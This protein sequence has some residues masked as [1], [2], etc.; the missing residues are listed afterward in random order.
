MSKDIKVPARL[1]RAGTLEIR[2][3]GGDD[4]RRV[5]LSF[6]SEEA[7]LRFFGW[8]VLG[9]GEGEVDLSRLASGRAPLLVDHS[10]T[11]D[12]QV[13]VVERAWI[14]DGKG[15]AVVR[16][17]K[18]PRADEILA[19]V[20]DGEVTGVSVGYQISR[21]VKVGERDGEPI[22]RAHWA[23]YEITLCPIPA[24]PGVGVGRSAEGETEITIT[25]E[26]KEGCDMSNKNTPAAANTL[27]DG[28]R[29]TTTAAPV[30]PTAPAAPKSDPAAD[31]RA[32]RA[33]VKDIRT[34]GRK[35]KMDDDAVDAAIE[36]GDTVDKFQRA[37]L[38]SMESD[39]STATRTKDS[40]I[41]MSE[42]DVRSFSLMRAIRY[43]A[44]PTNTR[45][46]EA[47]AF[48]IEVSEAAQE[49]LG[50]DAKGILIPADVLSHQ[51]FGR[52]NGT[53][54]QEVG[55]PA[56][57]GALVETEYLDGSFIGLLRKRAALTRLG[58][59][60][61]SGLHGNVAIPRQTGGGTAYWVGEGNGP[62]DSQAA[63]NTLNMTPHTLAAAVPITRRAMLQTT[64][65]MEA[66]VRDDLIRTM[67]LEIDRVG[68]NG[69]ADPDAPDGL[70]DAVG[71]NTVAFAALGAP[72]W[73]EIVQ[74]ESEIG[75][76]DAD[77]DGM[78]YLF[79]AT[80]RG[81]L[82]STPK[83]DGTAEFM[84]QGR[85][86]NGYESVVS[87]NSPANSAILG[88]WTDFVIGAW[89]GLD[90]TVDTATLAASGGT[91]IRAFQ[92]LDFGVRHVESFCHGSGGV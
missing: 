92:D 42:K 64:P 6:S 90:L 2:A 16:F 23:P 41:G 28:Q 13:G 17:G 70:L 34:L 45:A 82:K 5:E 19:R 80:M 84:M 18:H 81:H 30:A 73:A 88:N 24:D 4:D 3:M 21:F 63:F 85:E 12:A 56:A 72:T 60:M 36:R 89:S 66:L 25:M 43:L 50:R 69:D 52:A 48:E 31:M 53:R 1:A 40:S 49:H 77:V 54:A 87:N 75:A 71:I 11:I 83:V 15:R 86:V 35:F 74:M 51:E 76:D 38:D 8:E 58:V 55:T 20:R 57:G 78:K 26:Q 9:H 47:A 79:N 14:A 27:E 67:A 39:T 62:T 29:N 22:L 59:R 33:R 10:Q 46:R 32:E 68:I 61:L 65:S 37:I 91:Y 44:D 7:V